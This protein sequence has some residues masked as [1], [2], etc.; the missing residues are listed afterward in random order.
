LSRRVFDC[1]PFGAELDVLRLRLELLDPVVDRFVLAEAPTTFSGQAKPLHYAEHRDELAAYADKIIHVVVDDMPLPDAATGDRWVPERFQRQAIVRGLTDAA[2]D[3]LV[4]VSDVDELIDP[5]VVAGPL[6]QVDEPVALEM[7]LAYL[8]ANWEREGGWDRARATS[9]RHVAG[10]GAAGGLDPHELR[11]ADPQMAVR[12]AGAHLSYLTDVEGIRRKLSG[13]AHD[14]FDNDIFRDHDYLA[15]CLHVGAL[16]L[17]G[18]RLAVLGPDELSAVQRFVLERRPDLFD[19][20]V[21]D[22]GR[23]RAALDAYLQLRQRRRV[24]DR[25]RRSMDAF[26]RRALESSAPRPTTQP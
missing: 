24:P 5:A 19:F 13:A 26:V 23:R 9:A 21:P 6:Q 2:P 10:P 15:V 18:R 11:Y 25:A 17:N 14:E 8:R 20:D 22:L 1:F 16:P 7:R 4:L 12:E 3:D